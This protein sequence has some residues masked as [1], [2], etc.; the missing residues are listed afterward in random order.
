MRRF[1][2][3][4]LSGLSQGYTLTAVQTHSCHA[5]KKIGG[6][7]LD[8]QVRVCSEFWGPAVF[9]L[10]GLRSRCPSHQLE[11][12]CRSCETSSRGSCTRYIQSARTSLWGAGKFG[13]DTTHVCGNMQAFLDWT[14]KPAA[15]EQACTSVSQA[16]RRQAHCF[17]G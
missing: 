11:S 7:S 13:G 3:S 16:T 4:C 1:K 12:D 17:K 5:G 15:N 8:P 6:M 9:C 10:P 14:E 2:C